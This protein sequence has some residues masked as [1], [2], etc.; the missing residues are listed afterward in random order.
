MGKSE[1]PP[2]NDDGGILDSDGMIDSL[3]VDC[4]EL[5]KALFSGQYVLF[6]SMISQ[7]VQK[8]CLLKKGIKDDSESLKKQ[9]DDLTKILNKGGDTDVQC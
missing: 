7:M 1:M 9:I 6:C 3:I 5:P 4:N 2:V 8:L